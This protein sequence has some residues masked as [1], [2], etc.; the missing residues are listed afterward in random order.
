MSRHAFAHPL[1]QLPC[2]ER[3]DAEKD[4]GDAATRGGEE[5]EEEKSPE[6]APYSH[7]VV[8]HVPRKGKLGLCLCGEK[9]GAKLKSRDAGLI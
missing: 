4:R 8:C 6:E 9:T 5:E 2:C 7:P 1:W 3:R